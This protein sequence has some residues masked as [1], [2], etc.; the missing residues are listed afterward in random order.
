MLN[1]ELKNIS[2]T[3]R[4]LR[5]FAWTVGG[6]AAVL[7][8]WGAWRGHGYG[9]WIGAFGFVVLALGVIAPRVLLPVQKLWMGIAVILGFVMT[10][11]ILFVFFILVLTP[12][13]VL[14]RFSGKELVNLR[15]RTAAIS[16]WHYRTKGVSA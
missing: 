5:N 9:E 8:E 1:Q 14:S 6:V 12:L 3:P 7:G 2:S 16:Y 11:V 15:F 4:E 13:G 10:R